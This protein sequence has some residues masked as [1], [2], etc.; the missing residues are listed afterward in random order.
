MAYSGIERRQADGERL[1]VVETKVEAMQAQLS[2]IHAKLDKLIDV[3][4]A[5]RGAGWMLLRVFGFVSA[6]GA[7]VSVVVTGIY[8]TWTHVV[9][10]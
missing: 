4:A 9:F 5:G 3:L 1:A 10:K 7:I 6:F 2:V 8:W